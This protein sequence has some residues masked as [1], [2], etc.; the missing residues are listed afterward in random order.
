MKVI[1]TFIFCCDNLW[2]SKFMALEKPGKLMEFLFFSLLLC[3]HP[4]RANLARRRAIRLIETSVRCSPKRNYTLHSTA[5]GHPP[6][7]SLRR[8]VFYNSGVPRGNAKCEVI[9]LNFLKSHELLLMNSQAKCKI[10]NKKPLMAG[11]LFGSGQ[12]RNTVNNSQ[13]LRLL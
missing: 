4:V 12:W 8:S 1:I 10:L 5:H 2:T 7:V 9:K 13:H 11:L 3:G 6:W